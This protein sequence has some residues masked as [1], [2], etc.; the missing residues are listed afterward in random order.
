MERLDVSVCETNHTASDMSKFYVMFPPLFIAL[1]PRV[2]HHSV[3]MV[4]GGAEGHC[5]CREAVIPERD[6]KESS[7]A[8]GQRKKKI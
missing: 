7:M 5:T 6:Q 1:R 3:E 4:Y 2:G 8:V